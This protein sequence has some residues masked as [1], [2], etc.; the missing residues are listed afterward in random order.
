VTSLLIQI[1]KAVPVAPF[2]LKLP[3]Q[4]PHPNAQRS[5]N[6]H[7]IIN[8]RGLNSSL[9]PTNEYGGKVGPL[10]QFL[11][12]ELRLFPFGSHRLAQQTAVLLNNGHARFREQE[13]QNAAMSLTTCFIA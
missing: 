13:P 5:G 4:V 6:L 9:D 10:R 1:T 12:A 2:N 8:G 3:N 7:Q 11:L